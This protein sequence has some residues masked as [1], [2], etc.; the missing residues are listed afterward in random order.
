MGLLELKNE[1]NKNKFISY[2]TKNSNL[3]NFQ[4]I[5]NIY[6]YHPYARYLES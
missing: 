6:V 3:F 4:S 1:D 2:P 5:K